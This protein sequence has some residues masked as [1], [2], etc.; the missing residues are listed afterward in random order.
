MSSAQVRQV[1]T[2]A[3]FGARLE[4]GKRLAIV[5]VDFTYGFTDPVYPTASDMTSQVEAT[6]TLLDMAR[7]RNLPVIFTTI[8]YEKGHVKTL[9]WLRKAT[10]MASL[11]LGTR[12]VEIDGRLGR[13]ED[14]VLVVKHGASAF[15]GTDLASHLAALH[16]DTVVITGATTSGC[17]RASAVDAVQSGFDVLVPREC[18]ADR[19]SVPHDA[20]LFDIDQKYGDVIG[21]DDALD[22]LAG[23]AIRQA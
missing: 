21:L 12:L 18:V 19:A 6:R 7:S 11:L 3:G 20:N 22:Y 4:R 14:E 15:F 9:A 8:A 16:V 10:G 1:Y 5:V 2:T 17:V 13:R 23:V